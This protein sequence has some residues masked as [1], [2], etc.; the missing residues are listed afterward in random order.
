MSGTKTSQKGQKRLGSVFVNGVLVLI[1]LV[2]LIPTIGV[3]I[4]SFRN[5]EDIYSS[6]WWTVFPHR[7]WVKVEEIRVPESIDVDQP[8]EVAG[9][10]A[11]FST[12]R[13]G[14]VTPDG[15][16]ITWIGNK[17]SRLV[18]VEEKRWVGFSARL[19]LDNYRDTLS[20]ES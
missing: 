13:Q 20:G 16:K 4:T 10:T 19:T 9:V 15:R 18:I 12:L 2:W 11:D 5:S 3:F 7:G 14:I 6:G 17:R 1:C 8:F